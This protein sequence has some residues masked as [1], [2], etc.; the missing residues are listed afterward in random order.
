MVCSGAS[1]MAVIK[2]YAT[3]VSM[4]AALLLA[5]ASSLSYGADVRARRVLHRR[6]G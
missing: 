5:L 6:R 1:F 3:V 2:V 4:T